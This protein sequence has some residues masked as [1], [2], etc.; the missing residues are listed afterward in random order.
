M[1]SI[2][3]FIF[4]LFACSSHCLAHEQDV[5]PVSGVENCY[6]SLVEAKRDYYRQLYPDILFLVLKGGVETSEEMIVLDTLLGSAPA[7][8]DYEHPEDLRQDLMNISAHRIWLMLQHRLPSAALFKADNPL[9]WQENVCVITFDPCAM[10]TSDLSATAFLLDLPKEILH[11][12][13]EQLRLKNKDYIEYTMDHEVYHCL[14]SMYI[15]PQTMSEHSLWGE[16]NHYLEEKAADAFALAMHL[17]KHKRLTPFVRNL[18]RIRGV[19]IYN[20]DPD[21][22]TSDAIRQLLNVPVAEI[23]NM[24]DAEVFKLANQIKDKL[25]INYNEYLQYLASAIKA[26]EKLGGTIPEQEQLEQKLAGVKV[27][28]ELVNKL[29]ESTRQHL[30]E[31]QGVKSR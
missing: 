24:S 17:K 29:V 26:T 27:N 14:K 1:R 6:N 15:G 22:Y 25:T 16:Y 13:P 9:G 23:V 8:M 19:S 5:G 31:L 21:H 20:G 12:I 3:F 28:A 11:K 7:S 30:S 4:F 18:S 2:L 10:A